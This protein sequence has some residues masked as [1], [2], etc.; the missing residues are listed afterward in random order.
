[1]TKQKFAN[2]ILRKEIELMRL[3]KFYANLFM[4]SKAGI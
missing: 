3:E 2:E 4:S 1:M